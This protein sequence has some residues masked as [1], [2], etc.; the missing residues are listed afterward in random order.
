M[1]SV[2]LQPSKEEQAEDKA[3]QAAPADKASLGNAGSWGEL[4]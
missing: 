2:S 1:G 4:S 3:L